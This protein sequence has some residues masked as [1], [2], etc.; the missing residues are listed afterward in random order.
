ME[1]R[2]AHY[3]SSKESPNCKVGDIVLV[4]EEKQPKHMWRMGRIE[5]VF[6]GRDGNTR[7]CALRLPKNLSIKRPV[8]FIYPL[9]INDELSRFIRGEFVKTI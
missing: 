3:S 1:L 8:Q 9:E 5:Q 4:Y 2:S 6:V 7:S